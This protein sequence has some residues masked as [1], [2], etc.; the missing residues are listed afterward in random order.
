MKEGLY[1]L[2]ELGL[3]AAAAAWV[4]SPVAR[5]QLRRLATAVLAVA[6]VV[7]VAAVTWHELYPGRD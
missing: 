3:L 5:V 2:V 6:V 4:V 7:L 1:G